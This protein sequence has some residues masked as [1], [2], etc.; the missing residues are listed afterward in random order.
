MKGNKSHDLSLKRCL[1]V[2][3]GSTFCKQIKNCPKFCLKLHFRIK[4]DRKSR[5]S[6]LTGDQGGGVKLAAHLAAFG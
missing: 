3:S 1:G 4:A 5:K 6:A 2:D